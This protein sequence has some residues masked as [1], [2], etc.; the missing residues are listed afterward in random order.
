M[1]ANTQIV[2]A[3]PQELKTLMHSDE[4]RVKFAEALN[5][6]QVGGYISNVLITVAE[7]EAL[8]KCTP[9]SI[10]SAALRAA[11]MRL[12][13]DLTSGQ[14][15]LVPF[16]DKA[17]LVVGY[18]GLIHLALR[19]G[20][21]RYLNVGNIYKGEE[22]VEDRLT[23]LHALQ[24]QCTSKEIIGHLFY[25]E[26]TNGFKKTMYLTCE[27]CEDH[28]ARYSRSYDLP[29]S[30]WKTDPHRMH[31]K[32]LVRLCVTLY[33]Y[34]EPADMQQLAA[35]ES[36]DEPALLLP[37]VTPDPAPQLTDAQ[38]MQQLGFMD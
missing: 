6:K 37:E 2:K 26:M 23:G 35:D 12:S 9:V 20:R 16:K 1:T 34:L 29:K 28:G 33:G 30:V 13:V 7:N 3:K 24:G 19:T 25:M 17:T 4:I 31:A 11:T 8:Q 5:S 36:L 14:A 22:V 38:A 18:R 10:I 15:Y 21:Y 32:T 27:E